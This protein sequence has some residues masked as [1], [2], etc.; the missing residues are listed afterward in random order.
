[1]LLLWNCE[2]VKEHVVLEQVNEVC[3]QLKDVTAGDPIMNRVDFLI[4]IS[5]IRL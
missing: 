4:L 3:L 5:I 1:M 2:A